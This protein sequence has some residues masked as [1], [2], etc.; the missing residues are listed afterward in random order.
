MKMYP[1]TIRIYLAKLVIFTLLLTG[2]AQV[3]EFGNEMGKFGSAMTANVGSMMVGGSF[4]ETDSADSC[5]S[6]V[7]A[8]KADYE[9]FHQPLVT[10]AANVRFKQ[11][12]QTII[13]GGGTS[14][15][16]DAAVQGFAQDLVNASLQ[17]ATRD[18]LGSVGSENDGNY[19][20]VSRRINSDAF[21]DS[22]RLASV[23]GKI[24][25]LESCRSRQIQ[26]ITRDY[27]RKNITAKEARRQAEQVQE[28]VR[29][30]NRVIQEMVGQSGERVE[31]YVEADQY[32][33]QKQSTRRTASRKSKPS[34]NVAKVR[35]NQKKAKQEQ[36][37]I[38]KLDQ[39]IEQ[40]KTED[41][42]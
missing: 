33:A 2:C 26:A 29:R 38:A 22:S 30:D 10:R 8:L 32:V 20:N 37:K 4:P 35:E 12:V 23:R 40:I 31:V 14:G 9:Y 41:F 25:N 7:L 34:K 19:G 39:T 17:Q 11:A 21:T 18:Y 27:R 24:A 5:N 6:Q 3:K 13:Q 28:W 16:M 1:W 42:A 15:V 36:Q